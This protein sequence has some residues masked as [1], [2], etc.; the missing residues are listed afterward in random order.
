MTTIVRFD[1]FEV[2]LQSHR[3]SKRGTTLRLRDQPLT[4]LLTLLE[5]PGQVVTREE[6]RHRLWPDEVYVDFDNILNTAV[7]RLRD[8]LGDSADHPR[9]IETLPRHGYRFI[10]AVHTVIRP[11]G[12]L[13]P[14][15]RL[16]VLPF[17]NTSGD[18]GQDYFASAMTDEV[19]TAL[20]LFA[21]NG[22]AVIART[23][24]FH[25]KDTRKDVATIARELGLD[26]VVE[27]GARR[28]AE[29]ATLNVQLIRVSDQAHVWASRYEARLDEL[30]AIETA[31][32]EAIG[33]KLGVAPGTAA[34]ATSRKPTEDLEAHT[35]YRQGRHYL[36]RQ[37]PENFAAARR[38]FEQAVERDPRFALAY[39][40][41]A[42]LWWYFD[43]MGFAPPK[44]VAGI[45]MAYALR[46]LEIDNTLA[47]AHALLGHFRWLLDYDW[48]AVRRHVD[49][50]RELNPSSPMVRLWHAMG[51][52]LAPESRLEE[53]IDELHA[54]AED[55]PLS[56]L[57][58]AW[59]AILFHLD[60]Q[61]RPGRRGV[62]PARRA[63][64]R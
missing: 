25:Y 63:G 52:L 64:A 21:P 12:A 8:A 15:P 31:L 48:P 36:V 51:P 26:F 39:T 23:T 20:A 3:I 53:A 61:Y 29:S 46:A 43:F 55:D 32:T 22:L 60:R 16:L 9:F 1:P 42:E 59:L 54:A 37:T 2:D 49:R 41:L 17:M 27:G 28:G 47:D 13:A 57:I 30:L 35:L 34:I 58:R 5:R 6:L 45:G 7:A 10:A 24:S 33:A 19:I 62:A 11:D 18:P 38:C 56:A 4:V 14:R 44:T 50:A 40:A